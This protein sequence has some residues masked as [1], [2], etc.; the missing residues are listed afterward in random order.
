M[1][2]YLSFDGVR[3]RVLVPDYQGVATPFDGDR[4]RA[5]SF[6][7]RT[8]QSGS[9]GTICYWG[10][11]LT[12]N[13]NNG[14]ENRIRLVGNKLEL[15]GKGS[16]VQTSVPI[17]DGS[18]HHIVFNY[19]PADPYPDVRNFADATVYVDN[20][21]AKGQVFEDGV[22]NV[23]TPGEQAVILG[24]RPTRSGGFTDFF[25]GDLDEFAIYRDTLALA[26]ISGIYNGG[27]PGINL[28]TASQA[29]SLQ[30]WFKM[31]DAAGDTVPSGVLYSGTLVDQSYYGRNGV[32]FSGVSIGT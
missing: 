1:S 24:A 5:V 19:D 7:L 11:N 28:T 21:P 3:G 22:T 12:R 32:T 17:N 13:L 2:S 26:T 25:R 9:L 29:G 10:A 30:V 6:W 20:V 8:T 16:G 31:G 4:R 14:E 18:W 27:V 23:N 15:F